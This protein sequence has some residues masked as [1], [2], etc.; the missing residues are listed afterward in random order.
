[1][2]R[3]KF[4]IEKL[5]HFG[6]GIT[7]LNDK[8]L[9]VENAIDK[10][11]VEIDI[12]NDKKKSVEAVTTNI[13]E[14]STDR[15]NPECPYYKACGGC[16]IMHINYRKQLDFKLNKVSE[17]L[18]RFAGVNSNKIKTILPSS[19]FYYRNKVTLKVD[20]KLCFCKNKTCELVDIDEC[21]ICSKKINETIKVLNNLNL[22]NIEEVVIRT[23]YKEE[24]MIVFKIINNIDTEYF[25]RNLKNEVDTLVI[26]KDGIEE[27]LFGKGF[28]TE[29]IGNYYFK[30]SPTSF[31]QVNTVG[32]EKLYDTAKKYAELTGKE[33]VL[34]LYCGTGTIGIY[35]SEMA[36]S[37]TGVEINSEAVK[38][39][40]E[41]K[42]L[43][44]ITNIDFICKDVEKVID[45]YKDIDL[46]VLDPPRSGLIKNA[47]KNILSIKPKKIV[48]IS[49]DP[50]TLARDLNILK[51][52]YEIEEISLVDMFP[53][54]YHVE[55]VAS[56]TVRKEG[57]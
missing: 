11:V 3:D 45:K 40:N 31:F 24:T 32:A 39:A 49:C 17:L 10:E 46:V 22:S 47:I 28:I 16:N 25:I 29:K 26:I 33:K 37:V 43:N 30:I 27:I 54:T 6:R 13:I 56:L 2:M 53:N 50:A 14:K 9:F 7:R 48:Y 55:S 38:D 34:D 41:N 42:E 21:I 36:S 1:M 23:T 5:D 18:E 57:I 35:L 51:E 44:K 52:Y 20:K 4:F 15:K 19:D 8:I 12:L